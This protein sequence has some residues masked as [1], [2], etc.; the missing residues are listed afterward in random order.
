MAVDGFQ[1]RA[2]YVFTKDLEEDLDLEPGDIL[3]VNKASLLTPDFKEGDEEH[4]ELLGWLLGF[5]DRTKQ[6]GD[7]PGTYVQF[8]GPVRMSP[9]SSQLCSQRP[10]PAAPGPES[11]QAVALPDLTEQF[12]LPETA[13]PALVNLVEGLEKRGLGSRAL[14]RTPSVTNALT[15]SLSEELGS[16]MGVLASPDSD[17]GVLSECVL[18]YLRGL[19][20]PVIPSGVIPDLRAALTAAADTGVTAEASGDRGLSLVLEGATSMP[21]H[22][23]LTLTYLLTHLGRVAQCSHLNG[24]DPHALGQVF[25][26]LLIRPGTEWEEEF[27]ALLVE[28][29]LI[30]RAM[31]EEVPPP[32]LPAKPLKAKATSPPMTDTSILSDSEWYWGE[33]SREEVNEKMKDTPDGT[34]MVRDASSKLEGEY[35]LTLR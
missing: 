33:I 35:T 18:R 27:P 9:P 32:A 28:R 15:W 6:R 7:F 23:R 17:I 10:L 13:P 29:L 30:E 1:Y 19:P 21:L 4:P 20:S 24:L 16:D 3:T 5:N 25:G 12:T 34:F 26:P 22:H 2:L 31:G 8:V 11:Q 14:Y